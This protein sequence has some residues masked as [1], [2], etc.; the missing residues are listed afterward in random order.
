MDVDIDT[1]LADMPIMAQRDDHLDADVFN[2]WRRPRS[3]LGPGTG[4]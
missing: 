1:R 2:V 4:S 3:R